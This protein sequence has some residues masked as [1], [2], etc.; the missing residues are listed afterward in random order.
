MVV[1]LPTNI[2]DE[3]INLNR[4]KKNPFVVPSIRVKYIYIFIMD[5]A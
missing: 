3:N 2:L 1:D 5:D 4:I